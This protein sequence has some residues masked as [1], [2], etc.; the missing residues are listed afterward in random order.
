VAIRRRTYRVVDGEQI[1]GT[2]RHVFIHNGGTYFLADLLIY[3]DGL[4]DCWDHVDLDGLREKLKSGWVATEPPNG[5]PGE[6]SPS[7]FVD[8]R[9]AAVMD[10]R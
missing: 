5:G 7:G 2:W 1:P 6:R 10:Q 3:A 8:I 9:R 4:I